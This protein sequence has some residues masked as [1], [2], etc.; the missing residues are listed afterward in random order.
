MSRR[1]GCGLAGKAQD[2]DGSFV[3][4]ETLGNFPDLSPFPHLQ[5]GGEDAPR[6]GQLG[7]ARLNWALEHHPPQQEY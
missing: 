2:F 6:A 4:R 5:D 3:G 7:A 1:T